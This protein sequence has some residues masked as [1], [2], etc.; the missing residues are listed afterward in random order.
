MCIGLSCLD[1]LLS[2]VVLLSLLCDLLQLSLQIELLVLIAAHHIGHGASQ[3][4]QL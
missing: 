2:L 3:V 1:S 4:L